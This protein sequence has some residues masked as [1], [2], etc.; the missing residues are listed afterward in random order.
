[1]QKPPASEGL[2]SPDTRRLHKPRQR[3]ASGLQ[4]SSC[5]HWCGWAA[6]TFEWIIAPFPF[7]QHTNVHRGSPGK[8]QNLCC[9]YRELGTHADLLQLILLAPPAFDASPTF[10]PISVHF[11]PFVGRIATWEL[12]TLGKKATLTSWLLSGTR[13]P[14]LELSCQG[15]HLT[16]AFLCLQA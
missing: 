4:S 5:P 11:L 10:H 13:W 1:M 6:Q 8:P 9:C 3:S 12:I 7:S 14:S 2:H 15:F 16:C